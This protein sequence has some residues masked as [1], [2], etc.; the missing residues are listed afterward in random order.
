MADHNLEKLL[1]GFAAD[2]LTEEERTVLYA[3]ALQDQQLFNALADEQALKELLA[4]PVVRRRLLRALSQSDASGAGNSPSWLDRFRRPAGLAWAGGL[5]AAAFAVV[6]GTKVYQDSLRH[7]APSVATEE[8]GP[9]LLPAPAPPAS[10]P[11]SPPVAEPQPDAKRTDA[12]ARIPAEK[13]AL[14]D[15]VAKREQGPSPMTEEQNVS[16][17]AT[18]APVVELGK[19]AERPVHSTDNKLSTGST[20]PALAPAPL[21]A[22]TGAVATDRTAP[23]I[24]ARSLFYGEP[25]S[26]PDA[27]LIAQEK[28]AAMEPLPESPPQTGR[29]EER[30]DRLSQLSRAKAATMAAKPLGLRYSF[31]IRESNGMEREVDAKTA[32][33]STN[34]VRLT[35]E[36][37]QEAY[38]QI[39]KS[40]GVSPPQLLFPD[41]NSGPHSLKLVAGQRQIVPLSRARGAVSLFVRLSRIPPE[42]RA[43]QDIPLRDHLSLDRLQES[44]TVL[45]S[46]A[47]QEH[48]AYA[49]NRDVFSDQLLVNIIEGQ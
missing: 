13:N 33:T 42:P 7:A 45:E 40:V 48:A 1:G 8:T 15:R 3:A 4:D 36:T 23:T 44:H 11:P 2:T 27:G 41:G 10:Q 29:S 37:N 14:L 39:W 49:V 20:P 34:P 9:S 21:Q 32:A 46:I 16:E 43:E 24:S 18:D 25:A 6:L 26:P 35:V 38:L 28:K 5:A 22:L 31:V 47:G 30:L 17:A 19:A 12:P